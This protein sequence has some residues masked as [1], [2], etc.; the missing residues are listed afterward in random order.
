[1]IPAF[2]VIS[3][4][5]GATLQD[6][7]RYGYRQSGVPVSGPLDRIA[8]RLANGLVRNSA[9]ST[10]LEMLM[11]GPALEVIAESV[12]VA[13]V[14]GSAAM[15]ITTSSQGERSIPAGRS[16]RLERGDALKIGSLDPALCGYLAVEGGFVAPEVLGSASTYTRSALGGLDGRMLQQGDVLAVVR[17]DAA[18]RSELAMV[19]DIEAGFDRPIRIV[20]G[21]Q[22]DFFTPGALN[23]F[24]TETYMVSPQSDRMGFRL[25][26]PTLEHAKGYNIVSDGIVSGSIQVPGDGKPIVLMVDSQ[27]AGGYPK[28]ATV[29]SADIP[30][31]ARRKPG[32]PVRFVAVTRDEAENIRRAQEAE[33]Q[34]DLANLREIAE[35]VAIDLDALHDANLIDGVV[36]AL[37]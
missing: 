13:M 7:G 19:R 16:I 1:M 15:T 11:L 12:R 3:P 32:R 14:G 28:I 17:G 21:P 34:N 20:P 22:D 24:L 10:A 4:G 18:I 27:T 31:L 23:S 8:F 25:E 30:V 6:A 33:L 35:D 5:L 9:A 2:R 37:E 36:S 26:G 29:I